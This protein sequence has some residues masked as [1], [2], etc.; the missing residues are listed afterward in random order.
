MRAP[1]G[2]PRFIDGVRIDSFRQQPA[3]WAKATE[4]AL[5]D[6]VVASLVI[7]SRAASGKLASAAFRTVTWIHV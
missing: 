2:G 7:V 6:C 5:D 1:S 3:D 4:S